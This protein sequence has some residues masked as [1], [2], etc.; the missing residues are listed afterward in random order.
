MMIKWL[1]PKKKN[2]VGAIWK[3][4]TKGNKKVIAVYILIL[5]IIQNLM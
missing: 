5:Q 1:I 2:I 4:T 3:N